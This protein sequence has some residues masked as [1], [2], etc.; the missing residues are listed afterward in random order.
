MLDVQGKEV[1][2]GKSYERDGFFG[3]Y[4]EHFDD[5]GN[6]IGESRE[7]DGFFGKYVEHFDDD[8]NK[9]GES[10]DREGFFGRYT[11][12]TDRSGRKTGESRE[13]EGFFGKYTEHEGTGYRGDGSKGGSS[14]SSWCFLTT[15]CARARGL[16]DNCVELT[17]LRQFRDNYVAALPEGPGLIAEYYRIAPTIIAELNRAPDA[18]RLYAEIFRQVQAAVQHIKANRPAEAMRTYRRMVSALVERVVSTKGDA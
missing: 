1:H 15:A 14:S 4:V 8:G 3:K 18:D 13:R 17:T 10:R 6:K 5:D 2:M 11:E 7:R 16:D 9:I 12:H